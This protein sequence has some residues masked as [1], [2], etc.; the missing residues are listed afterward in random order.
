MRS[1]GLSNSSDRSELRRLK[2][3]QPAIDT[4]YTKGKRGMG[5]LLDDF[6]AVE[7]QNSVEAAH[8]REPVCDY[9]RGASLHQPFHR[10]LNQRFRFRIQARGGLVED[11]DRRARQKGARQRDTLPLATGQLDAAF[12]DQRAVTFRQPEDEVMRIGETCR[13]LDG[14]HAGARPAIGD[15]L[16]QR[17][18]KQDRVLLHNGD[19]AAQGLLGHPGDILAVNQDAAARNIIEPLHQLGEGGLAGT[20]AADE[21]D[22]F[23][24]A[25][26]DRETVIQRRSVIAVMEAHILEHDPSALHLDHRRV[27]NVDNADRLVM[28]S[29]KLLHVVDRTLQIVYVHADITQISVN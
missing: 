18:V 7:H 19:L 27:W 2:F 26:V 3:E 14:S 13:L 16:G 17:P 12:A 4:A 29:D 23:P 5:A 9:D 21:P 22:A 25:D 8:R 24:G 28:E 20:G 11:Q 10:L 1:A 15:V 6:T